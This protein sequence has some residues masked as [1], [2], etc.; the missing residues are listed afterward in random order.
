MSFHDDAEVGVVEIVRCGEAAI[1]TLRDLLF[2]REPSG[3]F[4]S[5]CRA[6]EALAALGAHSVL[7]EFLSTDRVARDLVE[8]LGD[9][10]VINA[11]ALALARSRVG[12]VFDL[13][14]HL[15]K[16]ASLTGV[17]GALG[18]FDRREAIPL[19]IDPLEDDASRPTAEAALK[20]MGSAARP[21]L[22]A[23]AIVRVPT[24][25]LES[26]SSLRRR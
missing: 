23:T 15:A 4:Q 18:S 6:V 1:P 7:I 22:I 14:L 16:R 11:T 9:D 21:A 3:L 8:R 19:L 20:R 17:I 5:R 25:E 13:L 24:A 2:S 26:E 10:A 12:G